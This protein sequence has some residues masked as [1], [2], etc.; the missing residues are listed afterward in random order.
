MNEVVHLLLRHRGAQI[1]LCIL[2]TIISM[3]LFADVLAPYDPYKAN[4]RD[5]LKPPSLDHPMGTDEIG[6]DI[7]SRIMYGARFSLFIAFASVAMG[8]IIGVSIGLLSGY[9]GGWIDYVVQR[10]TDILLAL[11]GVVLALALVAVLGPGLTNLIIAVGIGF[12]PVYIRIVRGVTLQVKAMEYV[13]AAEMLGL[14]SLRVLFKH[15]LP[16]VFPS[17]MVQVT[18]HLGSA[19]LAA[20]GLGFLGLGV[21]PPNPEWGA[22]IGTGRNYIFRA[23]HLIIFPGLSLFLVVLGFNL[24]GAALREVL[25]P[26]LRRG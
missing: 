25:D 9:Y 15:I 12:I 6:R 16:N 11:P 13:T 3:A 21:Q 8:A 10:M 26:R 17:V 23:P 18:L 7:L 19:V 2:L 22:M 1:G 24:L 20:A 14:S 5:A 4:L